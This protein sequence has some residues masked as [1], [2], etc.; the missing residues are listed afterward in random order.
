[1]VDS[2]GF[3]S[4]AFTLGA[5]AGQSLLSPVTDRWSVATTGGGSTSAVVQNSIKFSGNQAV[6]VTRTSNSDARFGVPNRTGVP[7]QRFVIID[8]DMRVSAATT[9]GGFGPFFGVDTYDDAGI[10]SQLGTFG[11]DAT[12]GELLYQLP[13]GNIDV[14]PGATV[15]FDTWQHY[16]M[17][18]DFSNDTY[19]G[20][21]NG[22]LRLSSTGFINP[23]PTV[24]EFTDGD[25]AAFAAGGDP[26]SLG[27]SASAVF[28]NFVI[29]DGLLGD[30]DIDGDVDAADYA[31]WRTTFGTA[32]SPAGNDADGNKN[33]VVDAG[34]YVIWRNNQGAAL[35]TALPGDYDSDGDVDAADYA[36]WRTTF[37][38]AVSPAGNNA[39]GNENGVVD[40]G[41]YVIWRNNEGATLAS[42]MGSGSVLTSV[43]IPEPAGF[44]LLMSA[45]PTFLFRRRPRLAN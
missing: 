19:Q 38:T 27:L 10:F 39:D 8:W 21:L 29:R 1:M 30:Y 40:A 18:L 28:D 23:G 20:Y 3:E 26:I 36:K 14:V 13:G 11:L 42:G 2:L 25:I 12:T 22:V 37:G 31:K 33:G 35:S 17:V 4:P 44:V 43:V 16:R 32:V 5:L 41:D 9:S 34:D 7:T 6:L 45:I 24:N 15:P